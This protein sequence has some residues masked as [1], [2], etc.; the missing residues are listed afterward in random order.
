MT[1]TVQPFRTAL[2]CLH[3]TRIFQALR[4][5]SNVKSTVREHVDGDRTDNSQWG[6][7]TFSWCSV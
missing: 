7:F 6:L 2:P 1:G 5:S 3:A 4:L